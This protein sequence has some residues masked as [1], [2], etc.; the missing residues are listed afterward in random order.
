VLAFLA[1]TIWHFY[2]VHYK[3]S[4]WP[5][6]TTWLDGQIR[7]GDLKEE[8]RLEYERLRA[9]LQGEGLPEVEEPPVQ[10]VAAVSQEP[11]PAPEEAGPEPGAGEAEPAPQEQQPVDEQ[12]DEAPDAAPAA[13]AEERTD[14]PPEEEAAAEQGAEEPAAPAEGPEEERP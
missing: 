2:H 9:E 1:I 5:M 13:G 4:I 14:L 11:P 10:A 8:H 12:A 6:N 3:P 7:L